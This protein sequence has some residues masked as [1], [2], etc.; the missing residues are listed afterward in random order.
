[1]RGRQAGRVASDTCCCSLGHRLRKRWGGR[2]G[3]GAG[4]RGK[5]IVGY[6]E[7]AGKERRGCAGQAGGG[8]LE[9]ERERS[10]S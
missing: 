9:R 7:G 3:I 2:G 1:M 6:R 10:C 5:E 4:G 8:R